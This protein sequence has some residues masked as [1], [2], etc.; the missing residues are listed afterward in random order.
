MDKKL[1]LDIG[2]TLSKYAIFNGNEIEC[3]HL[4]S[5]KELEE[6]LHS[7][8]VKDVIVSSVRSKS[9][10]DK[11]LAFFQNPLIL[12]SIT[13]LPIKV[14]YE[15][16]NTLGNDRIANAVGA[17]VCNPGKHSLVIDAGT[18]LKFDF[19]DSTGQYLGG[20]IS[21]GLQMRLKALHTFTDNLPLIEEVNW[22]HLIGNSTKSSIQSGA[23]GGLICEIEGMIGRYKEKFDNMT[24]FFTGG[25]S[26]TILNLVRLQKNSIFADKFITL[27]GLNAILTYNEKE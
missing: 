7:N 25:D 2:N 10:T 8:L 13:N 16:P 21:P 24:V 5:N 9:H 14:N 22:K 27:K 6:K 23:I 12:S 3:F 1:I 17:W 15:T 18:C 19:I 11:I 4:F 20:S 26:E